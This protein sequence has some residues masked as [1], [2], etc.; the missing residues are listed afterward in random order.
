M[1]WWIC[2]GVLVLCS[3]KISLSIDGL[4]DVIKKENSINREILKEIRDNIGKR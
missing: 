3:L 4:A 2:F 1:Q